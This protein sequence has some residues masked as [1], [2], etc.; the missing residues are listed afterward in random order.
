MGVALH[1]RQSLFKLERTNAIWTQNVDRFSL[2]PK[3]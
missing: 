2:L 3:Y 1:L